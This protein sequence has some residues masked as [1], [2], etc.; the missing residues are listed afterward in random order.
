MIE[1]VVTKDGSH[2][3][4]NTELAVWHHSVHGALQESM[5]V[6]IEIGLWAKMQEK[7]TI[8]VFEMGL[9]TGLNALL[10][11]LEAT[12][13]QCT[14]RYETIEAFPLTNEQV[15]SLNYDKMLHTSF[16][17]KIHAASW[18]EWQDLSTHFS[19]KKTKANLLDYTFEYPIDLVY[20]DAYS[21]TTQPELWTEDVFARLYKAMNTGALLTTYCSKSI[22][23]RALQAAGFI[24]EKHNGPIGKREILRAIKC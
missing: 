20:F 10:T 4:Y 16:L 5:R 9:G 21:P 19:I 23:R 12:T 18:H 24:V 3:F 7:T 2:T 14:V 22:V 11:A 6:F 13:K 15:A 17:E 8:N 1:L